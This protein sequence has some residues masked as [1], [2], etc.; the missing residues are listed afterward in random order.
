MKP[1]RKYATPTAFRTAL[2]AHL[3]SLADK[4][5]VDLQR[6]RR[7]VAFD[8]LLARLFLKQPAPWVLKGGYAMELRIEEARVTK[9]IDLAV[10]QALLGSSK[11]PLKD[12]I[13]EALQNH[14]ATD[15]GDFFSF[16]IGEPLED[17]EGPPE[18]GARYPVEARMD[19]R[20]FVQFHIDVA[21]GDVL[22]KPVDP[23]VG[24]DWLSFAGIPR[25]QFSMIICEQ[26]FA[27]KLHAYTRPRQKPNSRVRDL[28]DMIL[29]IKSNAMNDDKVRVATRAT[30]DRYRTHEV[31][32]R[33]EAP[34]EDWKK[35]YAGYAQECGLAE[36][37][38]AAFEVV[39]SYFQQRISGR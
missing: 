16:I 17:L 22:L 11:A 32:G 23:A 25:S 9:E 37:L 6:L 31:P 33:L 14:A 8:R 34:P 7:E 27:E 38:A 24:R 39:N 4:E 18:G 30:F 29:L 21:A 28:V 2:E 19:G 3:R 20:T 12:A 1:A 35:P 5:N 13:L 26:H 36:D 15:L 10:Q